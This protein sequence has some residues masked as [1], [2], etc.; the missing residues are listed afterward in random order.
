MIPNSLEVKMSDTETWYVPISL[1]AE[2]R[3]K[4]YAE[5]DSSRGDGDY[6]EVLQKEYQYAIGD[7]DELLDWAANNMD[8]DDVEREAFKVTITPKIDYQKQWVNGKKRIIRS[9]T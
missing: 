1:I 2:N 8:W 4:Y 7:D 6:K 3:A 5:L 9:A